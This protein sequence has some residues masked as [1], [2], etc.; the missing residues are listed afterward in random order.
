MSSKL[1]SCRLENRYEHGKNIW[2]FVPYPIRTKRTSYQLVYY[3][4]ITNWHELVG[5]L[6]KECKKRWCGVFGSRNIRQ[7][8]KNRLLLNSTNN[9]VFSE[10]KSKFRFNVDE[11]TFHSISGR[12][13][14]VYA[15]TSQS[16]YTPP[17]IVNES[18]TTNATTN[19]ARSSSLSYS[20]AVSS[21]SNVNSGA[22]CSSSDPLHEGRRSHSS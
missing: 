19:G 12:V 22:S 8:V 18:T 17:V 5:F 4:L 9:G 11:W 7:T 20:A 6:H 3:L 13:Y 1:V 14:V 15:A 2:G 21:S 10:A 16:Q